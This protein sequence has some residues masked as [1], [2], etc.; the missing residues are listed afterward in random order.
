[1]SNEELY[2]KYV[3]AW[4]ASGECPTPE[5]ADILA[6]DQIKLH[7]AQFAEN[8]NAAPTNGTERRT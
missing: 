2:V 7:R 3:V 1:M 6:R 8:W 5:T 4:I